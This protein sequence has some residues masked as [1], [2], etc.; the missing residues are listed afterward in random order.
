MECVS[1]GPIN[2]HIYIIIRVKREENW[3][4]ES[5]A[6]SRSSKVSKSE[7]KFTRIIIGDCCE[8]WD[9]RFF[10]FLFYLSTRKSDLFLLILEWKCETCEQVVWGSEF[11]S[12]DYV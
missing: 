5:C 3:G 1:F 9:M 8:V 6:L 7:G 10:L 2:L 11:F 12:K 4:E